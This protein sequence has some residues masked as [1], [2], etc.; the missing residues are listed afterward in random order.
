M[1]EVFDTFLDELR[2][3]SDFGQYLSVSSTFNESLQVLID[4]IDRVLVSTIDLEHF[5]L[6]SKSVFFVLVSLIEINFKLLSLFLKLLDDLVE[7]IVNVV[8]LLLFHTS[9]FIASMLHKTQIVV[10]YLSSAVHESSQITHFLS[11]NSC[12]FVQLSQIVAIVHLEHAL[13][14]H[15]VLTHAAKVF[16]HLVGVLGAVNLA[17]RS[18]PCVHRANRM[19][20]CRTP[21]RLNR[22]IIIVSLLTTSFAQLKLV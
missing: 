15:Q 19:R 9:D 17:N 16:N 20:G 4:C 6:L 11:H 2:Y 22:Q 7:A 10:V 13:G 14:A 21:M 5:H 8:K 3:V 18:D 12:H 1:L